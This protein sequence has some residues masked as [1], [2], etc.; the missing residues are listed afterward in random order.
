[1]TFYGRDLGGFAL[2]GFGDSR[3]FVRIQA[4]IRPNLALDSRLD[5]IRFADSR[6]LCESSANLKYFV[7]IRNRFAFLRK[8][9]AKKLNFFGANPKKLQKFYNFFKIS[10]KFKKN[11][12]KIFLQLQ[13]VIFKIRVFVFRAYAKS[14]ARNSANH[15]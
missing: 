11:K 6:F 5:S 14:L 9:F 12:S 2:F 15:A 13:R 1:M 7:T 10:A 4:Q 8:Y 3:R